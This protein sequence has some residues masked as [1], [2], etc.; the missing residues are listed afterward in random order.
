MSLGDCTFFGRMAGKQ[1]A[2]KAF[3]KKDTPND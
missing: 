3:P 2:T 1:A